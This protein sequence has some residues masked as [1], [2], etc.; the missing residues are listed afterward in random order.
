M[1]ISD[2]FID[3]IEK[4]LCCSCILNLTGFISVNQLK[5]KF[6]RKKLNKRMNEQIL[7]LNKKITR[8][9]KNIDEDTER[10]VKINSDNSNRNDSSMISII[11]PSKSLF[12]R[13]ISLN[14]S[15]P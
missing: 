5:N 13:P 14:K 3:T 4:K 8:K 10:D 1:N 7:N 15:L 12:Q 2:N 11:T 9:L 6:E